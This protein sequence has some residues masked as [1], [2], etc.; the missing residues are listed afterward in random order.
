MDRATEVSL[1][2]RILELDRAGKREEA[3]CEHR[4]P[5]ARYLDPARQEAEI[6]ALFRRHPLVLGQGAELAAPGSFVTHDLSGL[7][8]L[9]LRDGEGRFRAFLNVCRHRGA[10]IEAAARGTGRRGFVCPYHGWR[11]GLDGGVTIGDAKGFAGLDPAGHGLVELPSAEAYG[12]LWVRP[13]VPE[14]G[15]ALTLDVA[16]YLGPLATDFSA[17][18][19][20]STHPDSPS[21]LSEAID[22][23]VMVDTFLEDY[24]FR[25]VHG[26][27]VHRLYLDDRTVYD[28]FGP[29]IRYVIPKRSI[30]DLAGT[31]PAEWRLREHSNVLYLL[32]PNTV[33]VFVGDHAAIFAMF[34]DGPG[35]SVM[36]LS[37]CLDEEPSGAS[38]VYWD[39]QIALIK[40][41]LAEDFAVARGVQAN[42]ASGANS[43]LTFGRY[44]KG[45]TYFHDA[46]A[47]ALAAANPDSGY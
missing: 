38:R 21:H 31:D 7:P 10:R 23:K 39:K 20:E 27:S 33:L 13:S 6:D 28:R 2:R 40:T 45:L 34:P 5:V 36:R 47:E 42:F 29:H 32:F 22:W 9:L 25:F 43:H 11:Y 37:F 1:I 19:L 41:A 44:E 14:A 15:E 16:G 30:R 24:H 18:G 26:K 17:W 12:L 3:E 35:R 8:M 46:I 4:E